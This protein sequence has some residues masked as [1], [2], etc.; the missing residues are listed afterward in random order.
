MIDHDIKV[1]QR[2]V[3]VR[4]HGKIRGKVTSVTE[5][6]TKKT[7]RVLIDNLNGRSMTYNV[8]NLCP[9]ESWDGPSEKRS[10]TDG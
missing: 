6:E 3:H 9:E 7:A 2:V 10:T 4:T 8:D 1:G 5:T